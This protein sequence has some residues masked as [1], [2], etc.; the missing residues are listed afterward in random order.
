MDD[1]GNSTKMFFADTLKVNVISNHLRISMKSNSHRTYYLTLF[2]CTPKTQQAFDDPIDTWSE[3]MASLNTSGTIINGTNSFINYSASTPNRLYQD[4]RTWPQF[5]KYFSCE[6]QDVIINPGETSMVNF[7]L[8]TGMIDFKKCLDDNVLNKYN[9]YA[10]FLFAKYTCDLC[11]T[12]Q[13]TGGD[14]QYT[15][16]PAQRAADTQNVAFEYKVNTKISMPEQAGF[17]Y[18]SPGTGTTQPLNARHDRYCFDYFGSN[19]N[20]TQVANLRIDP[21]NPTVD[22]AATL[23]AFQ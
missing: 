17:I 15:K 23:E 20:T 10:R 9:K 7:N 21:L 2:M 4:P 13:G 11:E 8:P 14:T 1:I 3:A 5:N 18:Q 22:E 12:N 19:I 16:Q 6:V